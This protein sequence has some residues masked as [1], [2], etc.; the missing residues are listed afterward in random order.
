MDGFE[1]RRNEKKNN[2]LLAA[3][4]LFTQFGFE[5]VKMTDIA[6][7]ARVSK[8]SIYNFYENKDNIRRIIIKKMIHESEEQL[9]QLIQSDLDF[10]DKIKHYF[11]MRLKILSK[12]GMTNSQGIHFFY[13]SIER[14]HEIKEYISDHSK[15]RKKKLIE[16]IKFGK[17]AGYFSKDISDDAIRIYVDMYHYYFL[18]NQHVRASVEGKPNL[19]EEINL[20]FLDGLIRQDVRPKGD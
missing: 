13:D 10:I 17:K 2:I 5:R 4:E 7:K 9:D 8:A 15:R 20:L 1:K 14:D 11:Q 6:D 16:F 12:F 3:I 19:D 18:H